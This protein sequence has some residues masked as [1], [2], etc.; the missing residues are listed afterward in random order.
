MPKYVCSEAAHNKFWSYETSGTTATMSWGRVGGHVSSQE[1][2]FDNGNEL[3]RFIASKVDEKLRKGYKL[4]EEQELTK[5]VKVAQAI[6]QQNKIQR[7]LWAEQRGDGLREIANYDPQQSVYVELL[8]SWSKDVVRVLLTKTSAV[9]LDGGRGL[10][11]SSSHGAGRELADGLR[12]ALRHLAEE[13]VRAFRTMGGMDRSLDLGT[14]GDDEDGGATVKRL[15]L[16]L[17]EQSVS[18]QAIR[19]FASL[20]ERTLEL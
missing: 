6:G 2:T 18:G 12:R 13:V 11:Y 15:G 10:D 14:D 9:I 8:N 5:Q 19:K 4:V 20:G 7:L 3:Q 17:S 16:K 1:K